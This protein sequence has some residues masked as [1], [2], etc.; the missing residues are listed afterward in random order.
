M[1]PVEAHDVGEAGHLGVFFAGL[2]RTRR[3]PSFLLTVT[4]LYDGRKWGAY[5]SLLSAQLVQPCHLPGST[6][7]SRYGL[8]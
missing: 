7:F 5:S 3:L 1:A 2:Q 4:C 8:H 6:S